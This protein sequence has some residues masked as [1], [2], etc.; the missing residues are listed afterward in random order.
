MGAAKYFVCVQLL[1]I[2][3]PLGSRKTLVWWALNILITIIVSYYFSLFISFILQCI[4][5]EAIWNTAV[6]GRCVDTGAIAVS[7]GTMNLILDVV[8]LCVPLWA[9]GN[10]HLSLKLKLG[11]ASVFAVGIL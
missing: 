8:I 11:A 2:F 3:C 6:Q 7:T 10:L 5:R 9:I 4:P 1:R